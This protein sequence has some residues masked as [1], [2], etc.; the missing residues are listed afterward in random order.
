MLVTLAQAVAAGED[1]TGPL[2]VLSAVIG[3]V[4]ALAGFG[5][6]VLNHRRTPDGGQQDRN[7]MYYAGGVAAAAGLMMAAYG[8]LGLGS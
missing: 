1:S 7:W 2:R 5:L 3:L 6:L 4:T 8:L